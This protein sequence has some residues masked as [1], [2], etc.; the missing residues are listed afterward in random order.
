MNIMK[1][2]YMAY[3]NTAYPNSL[4]KLDFFFITI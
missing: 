4:I 3:N 1:A 2:K